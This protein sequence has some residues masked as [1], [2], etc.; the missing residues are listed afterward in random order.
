MAMDSDAARKLVGYVKRIETIRVEIRELQSDVATIRKEAKSDGFDATKIMEVVRWRE[1][2]EKYG[3]DAMAEAEII[4]DLYRDA[5]A[6][7]GKSLDDIM[8]SVRDKALLA[9]FADGGELPPPPTARSKAAS[10]ALA[11]AA[12]AQMNRGRNK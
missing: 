7:D 10:D 5:C 9:Q 12:I 6:T 4:F 1:K 2:V 11:Y 8:E 3:K